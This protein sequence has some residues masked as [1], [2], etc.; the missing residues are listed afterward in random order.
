M[1]KF[2]MLRRIL[3]EIDRADSFNIIGELK[4]KLQQYDVGIYNA[5]EENGF[6]ISVNSFSGSNLLYLAFKYNYPVIAKYL[7]NKRVN[8]NV[9]DKEGKA[10]YIL[11]ITHI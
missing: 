7:I 3:Y 2:F 6:D 10:L 11:L 5:W 4:S 1:D 9:Q 8:V